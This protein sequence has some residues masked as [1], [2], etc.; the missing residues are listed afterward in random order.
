[1]VTAGLLFMTSS[2]T[3]DSAILD[4][5]LICDSLIAL[6]RP[7][8]RNKMTSLSIHHVEQK[9]PYSGYPITPQRELLM[10]L[11]AVCWHAETGSRES[12]A[13]LVTLSQR[14]PEYSFAS[15]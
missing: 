7:N 9:A 3:I 12:R 10:W 6:K 8:A 4:L 15:R 13:F 5:L 2:P 1:M 11:Q 14:T